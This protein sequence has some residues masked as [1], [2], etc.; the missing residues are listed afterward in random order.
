E[1]ARLT[2]E[3]QRLEGEIAKAQ[4]KLNNQNFVSKA[5][6]AVVEQEKERV[7]KFGEQLVQVKE[8]MAKLAS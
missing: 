5:P 3:L 7:V 4:A 2:K 6:I 1:L 8:Q